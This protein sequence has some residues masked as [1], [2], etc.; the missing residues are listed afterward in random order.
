[1][2]LQ[3]TQHRPELVEGWLGGTV[4]GLAVRQ[5]HSTQVA[6][7]SNEVGTSAFSIVVDR[8]IQ[9]AAVVPALGG[10]C[11]RDRALSR[12]LSKQKIWSRARRRDDG[13]AASSSAA[14][15]SPPARPL[16]AGMA[17]SSSMP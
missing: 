7:R 1:M 8:G 9:G 12:H 15:M 6:Q 11:C 3:H 17:P 14:S 13:Y 4:C 5:A 2:V 10:P 16:A